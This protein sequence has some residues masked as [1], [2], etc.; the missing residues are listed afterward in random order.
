MKV[1]PAARGIHLLLFLGGLEGY[2]PRGR[3]LRL[4]LGLGKMVPLWGSIS[5]YFGTRRGTAH[6]VEGNTE[7]GYNMGIG[8]VGRQARR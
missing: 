7:H 1:D 8:T 3:R 5:S 2:A 4:R 6:E